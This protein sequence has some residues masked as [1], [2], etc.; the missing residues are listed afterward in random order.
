MTETYGVF[1]NS[2]V[3]TDPVLARLF[4]RFAVSGVVAS[5]EDADEMLAVTADGT[6]E[7]Q[8]RPGYALVGGWWYRTDAPVT[9]A[10]TPNASGQP[11]RDLVVVRASS[12]EETCSCEILLGTPGSGVAPSPT[13]DPA[14]TWEVPLAEI[15]VQAGASTVNTA[16]VTS[17]REF[18]APVGAVPVTSAVRHSQL[19]PGG[20]QYETDTGRLII[21]D[22]TDYRTVHDPAYPTAWVNIPLASGIVAYRSRPNGLGYVPRYRLLDAN[23]VELS[24]IVARSSGE[25]QP[26]TVTIGRLPVGF[27]PNQISYTVG[28]ASQESPN[29]TA[30]L[31]LQPDG[32]IL[33]YLVAGY[34]PAWISLDNW[35]V[36]LT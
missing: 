8:V 9:L 5:G 34:T 10:V 35:R 12:S 21:G 28:A 30:R 7:I 14:G 33:A 32:D 19:G 29:N 2:P 36:P 13:R 20:L 25:F 1:A 27:R 31:E 16:D 6:A 15:V 26:P 18:T 11:R 23:T 17:V 3:D 4:R 24:G 22:G